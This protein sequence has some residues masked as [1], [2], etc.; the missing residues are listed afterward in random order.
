MKNE[1]CPALG[2][3][4][5]RKSYFN[6]MKINYHNRKFRA[7]SNSAA[8]QVNEET[9]FHYKQEGNRLHATYIGGKIAFGEMLGLVNDD[10]TLHFA[11]HHIDLDGQLKSGHCNSIPEILEDGRI[12]LQE[13]WQ[14]DFG[15]EGDGSS[16]VEEY[17]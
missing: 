5:K 6:T 16:I 17:L 9:V 12:R 3:R 14:W 15:G 2:R 10:N 1:A 8:G 4:A 7:V 13:T 11:Y